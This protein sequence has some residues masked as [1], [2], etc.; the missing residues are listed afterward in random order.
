MSPWWMRPTQEETELAS[1]S[2]GGVKFLDKALLALGPII[3]M[4]IVVFRMFDVWH[5]LMGLY[6]LIVWLARLKTVLKER[7]ARVSETQ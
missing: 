1:S 6:I 3:L 5:I 2:R 7:R 4:G